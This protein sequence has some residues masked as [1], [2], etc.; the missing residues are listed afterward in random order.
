M[1]WMFLLAAF[2]MSNGV[3][4]ESNSGT[5]SAEQS[6]LVPFYRVLNNVA[7]QGTGQGLT[8]VTAALSTKIASSL[9]GCLAANQS[10]CKGIF[11]SKSRGMGSNCRQEFWD[12]EK[13]GEWDERWLILSLIA[14]RQG[15]MMQIGC[16][17]FAS[18]VVDWTCT[19]IKSPTPLP[20]PK[21]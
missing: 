11:T 13:Y 10:F 17:C 1:K 3:R 4:A 21:K 5:C 19:P 14:A 8:S 7:C 18:E 2:A 6:E 12:E 16:Y 15:D 20:S 9:A